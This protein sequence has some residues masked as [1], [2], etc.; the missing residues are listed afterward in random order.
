MST[1]SDR[2]ATEIGITVAMSWH[3]T[4]CTR[5]QYTHNNNPKDKIIDNK[6]LYSIYLTN[7]QSIEQIEISKVQTEADE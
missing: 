1:G 7:C 4:W 5:L 3:M 2:N 6:K